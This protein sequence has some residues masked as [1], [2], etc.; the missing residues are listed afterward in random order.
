M[1]KI[2]DKY[3]NVYMIIQIIFKQ[4]YYSKILMNEEKKYKII[5]STISY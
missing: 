1:I 4:F 3:I 2:V 5:E